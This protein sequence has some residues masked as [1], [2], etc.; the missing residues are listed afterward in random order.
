MD[1]IMSV[2]SVESVEAREKLIDE[3]ATT[4]GT[5]T[6]GVLASFPVPR[7]HYCGAEASAHR[8][9]SHISKTVLPTVKTGPHFPA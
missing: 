6:P 5:A 1:R 2:E 8:L 3:V 9:P 7:P 4:P